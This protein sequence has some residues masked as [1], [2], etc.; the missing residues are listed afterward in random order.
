VSGFYVHALPSTAALLIK[1]VLLAYAARTKVRNDLTR[2]F[3]ALVLVLSAYNLVEVVGLHYYY[4]HGFNATVELFGYFYFSTFIPTL[5]ILLHLSLALSFDA[6]R[7][8][9]WRP[10]VALVYLPVI[11]LEYLLLF[12]D[13][14]I[15]GF[16]PFHDS[17]TRRPGELYF[18]FETYAVVYLL[19]TFV[20]LIYGARSSRPSMQR[21]RN[22]LWLLGLLPFVLMFVYL[23]VAGYLGLPKFTTTFFLPLAVTFFLIVTTYATHQYRLFDIEFFLPWSKVR[24]RKT[25][26]YARIQS[27]IAEIAEMR[28]VREVLDCIANALSCQVALVGGP[29][30]LVATVQGQEPNMRDGLLLSQFPRAALQNVRHI[31]VANEIADTLPELHALMKQHKV[32]AIV[33]FNPHSAVSAHWMLLGERFSDN[34]YTPLDFKVAESLFDR[35]AELFLENFALLRAQL[36]EAQNETREVKRRLAMAWDELNIVRHKL[37]R[38]EAENRALREEK[39]KLLRERL[40]VVADDLPREIADGE[41]TLEDYLAM[42]E[43]RILV[44]ALK[45]ARGNTAKAAR[46]LGFWSERPLQPL[47]ERHKLDPKD[48]VRTG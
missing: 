6:V 7:E 20:H 48:F 38:L 12:T 29:R 40:R 32:G 21:T 37:A 42:V 33:P 25:A 14:L 34:V 22:R 39:A 18:L 8:P 9:R 4:H 3:L 17:I 19:A 47:L 44:A 45:A 30:P 23:V 24:K 26:F 36:A 41:Q 10:Y 28:S 5:A 2:L 15:V 13:R 43:R 16:E 35:I 31:V 11:P 1:L 27:V 46:L